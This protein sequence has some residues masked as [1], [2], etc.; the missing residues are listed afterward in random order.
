[1][2]KRNE[3]ILEDRLLPKSFILNPF[4]NIHSKALNKFHLLLCSNKT[5]KVVSAVNMEGSDRNGEV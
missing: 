3:S 2:Q 1:M 4:P 5:S